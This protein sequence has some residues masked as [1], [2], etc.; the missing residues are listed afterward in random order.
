MLLLLFVFLLLLLDSTLC[1]YTIHFKSKIYGTIEFAQLPA[2]KYPSFNGRPIYYSE[3]HELYIYHITEDDEF[4]RWVVCISLEDHDKAIAFIDSWAVTP[5]LT[6][7]VGA[8][9]W[10]VFS[11]NEWVTEPLLKVECTQDETLYFEPSVAQAHMIAGFYV[12][13]HH[14]PTLY[15]DRPIYSLINDHHPLAEHIFLHYVNGYWVIGDTV[16]KDSS[17]AHIQ[18]DADSPREIPIAYHWKFFHADKTSQPEWIE[19]EVASHLLFSAHSSMDIYSTLREHR[20][21]HHLPGRQEF[22][23]LRNGVQMPVIGFGTG[24]LHLEETE[25]LLTKAVD[26]GYRMFDLAREYNNEHII[27]KVFADLRHSYNEEEGY[28]IS[29][30]LQ[31]SDFFITTKVWPTELG[32]HATEAA[33]V[34]SLEAMETNYID[35]YLIHWPE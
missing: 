26:A 31:R 8:L 6:F 25:K 10:T 30:H 27:P 34:K 29:S 24:G 16:G 23:E 22:Y 14:T 12:L 19:G 28:H 20:K 35:L 21:L 33:I 32:F 11:N 2:D 13:R 4:G 5:Y 9:P 3:N 18:S 7:E 17:L 1:C 15:G